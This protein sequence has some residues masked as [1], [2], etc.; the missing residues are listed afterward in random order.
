[1]ATLPISTNCRPGTSEEKDIS[2]NSE[3]SII[4]SNS[5]H[6]YLNGGRP[7]PPPSTLA[8]FSKPKKS[9]SDSPVF[10]IGIAGG[11]ASGKT[12]VSETII[13]NINDVSNVALISMDSFYKCLSPEAS[14]KA[15]LNEYN[16]DH[17]DAF[18][19]PLLYETLLALKN[20]EPVNIPVYDFTTHSRTVE[21][22]HILGAKVIIFE[23]ILALYDRDV[24]SL[25]DMKIFVDTDADVRLSRRLKRD[26]NER[27]R[28][29]NG[30]LEQYNRF[31]KPSFDDFIQPSVKNA[32]IIIPRGRDNIVAIDL[33]TKHILTK[34]KDPN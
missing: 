18:E 4:C 3:D 5:L 19:F 27:K 8:S 31:V 33:I 10:I 7:S 20:S 16:F 26:I 1:M 28:D 29:L 13:K 32:D 15:Y 17:P 12:S 14:K 6:C 11:S 30:I 2:K 24:L 23:G 22:T 9:V 34:I 25:M 21:K